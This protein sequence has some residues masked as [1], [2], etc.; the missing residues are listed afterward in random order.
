[1]T[2]IASD[3]NCMVADSASFQRGIMFPSPEPKIA[4]AK[5]GSLV[6]P[7]GAMGDC[8][9]LRAWVR[10]GMDFEA[11]PKFSFREPTHD[12]SVLWLWLRGPGDLR[13]G[14]STMAYWSVPIP[15]VIGMGADFAHGLIVAGIDAPEAVRIAIRRVAYLGGDVQVERLTRAS[16]VKRRSL[17][18]PSGDTA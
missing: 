10:D 14:D 15:T 13:M 11:P 12:D 4:R 6:G 17:R 16:S 5:D 7:S 9:A 3:G 2:I 1:M 18:K 8:A